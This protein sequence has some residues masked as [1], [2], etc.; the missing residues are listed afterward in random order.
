MQLGFRKHTTQSFHELGQGPPPALP[1]TMPEIASGAA[2]TW[3]DKEQST[4]DEA[5]PSHRLDY[6]IVD[7]QCLSGVS[8]AWLETGVELGL[9]QNPEHA[10]ESGPHQVD[11]TCETNTTARNH[12]RLP[13][14]QDDVRRTTRVQLRLF[15]K[16]P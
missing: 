4:S 8:S 14:R 12:H 6:A 2:H 3:Y 16:F 13:T 15:V 5:R 10:V 7:L 11:H 9:G 1:S